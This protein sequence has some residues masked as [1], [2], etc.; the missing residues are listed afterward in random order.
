MPSSLAC[1]VALSLIKIMSEEGCAEYTELD[2]QWQI[3]CVPI[4]RCAGVPGCQ[5]C[6]INLTLHKGPRVWCNYQTL[7]CF[8]CV[9]HC[10]LFLTLYSFYYQLP[11]CYPPVWIVQN[12]HLRLLLVYIYLH[13]GSPNVT[14]LTYDEQSRTFTCTSTGGPATTVTWRRD[15]VVITPNATYQ[16]TKRV[17]DSVAGTYRTVLTISQSVDQSDIPGLY[18]CTVENARRHSSEGVVI[19]GN[20][21]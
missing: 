21:E 17:V 9:W 1:S 3:S 15:W 19:P 2:Q 14:S 4:Y 5:K 12:L 16:Q 11:S 18:E 8:Y 6:G 20:G 10:F 7:L 13:A